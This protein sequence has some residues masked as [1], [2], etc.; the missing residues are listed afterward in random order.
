[1]VYLLT[2]IHTDKEI[3]KIKEMVGYQLYFCVIVSLLFIDSSIEKNYNF[4]NKKF[5]KRY[6][7][8][9][10]NYNERKNS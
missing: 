4:K 8:N 10:E 5:K 6:R 9:K 1:M 3:K 2:S 7:L